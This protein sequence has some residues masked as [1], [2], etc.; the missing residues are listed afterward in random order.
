MQRIRH[1]LIRENDN[2]N[3]LDEFDFGNASSIHDYVLKMNL[4]E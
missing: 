2:S 4:I 3:K 1:S